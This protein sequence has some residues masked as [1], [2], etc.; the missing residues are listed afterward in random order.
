M[1][2]AIITLATVVMTLPFASL[3]LAQEKAEYQFTTIKENPITS[4]KNQNRTGTCWCY[5]GISF[6][7]SEA[8]RLNNLKE[9]D[10]PD[11]S[12]MF[13]VSHSYQDR[14]DKYVRLD[15]RL[16]FAAGSENED[17]LRVMKDYGFVPNSVMPG[18]NYGTELPVH[19]ELDALLRSYVDVIVKNPNRTLSTAWKLGFKGILDAYLGETPEQ[20]EYNGKTY[21]PAS[22]RDSYKLNPDDY[23]TLTSFTHHPFYTKF[24][25]EVCDNWRGDEAYNVPLDEFMNAMFYALEHGYTTT[26]AGDVS[27]QGF[28]RNGIGVL[29]DNTVKPSS[30]SD[31]ERWLGK[32]AAKAENAAKELPKEIAVTQE[33]RQEAF[34]TKKTT[35]DH[36]MHAFGIAK[37]QNGTKYVLIKNSWGESGA[38]KGI[39]Y[40]SESFTRAKAIQFMVHK[41]GL[42]KD[43]RKKLGI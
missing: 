33:Y 38:Y 26:W 24:A 31:Q 17:V 21:T 43:L 20:F 9:A 39:W 18:L 13:V 19:G 4:I 11:F 29:V 7:E 14:A 28:T 5:S 25:V 2:K 37:D 23:V 30:G 40:L 10:Y 15:G 1:K 16:A 36:G 35:D 27:E 22:Y 32:D 6:F 42:P 41:D 3:M 34:D 12:E 8:I